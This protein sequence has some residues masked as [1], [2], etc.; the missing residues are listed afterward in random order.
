MSKLVASLVA[1][2]TAAGVLI[3]V[4]AH[5]YGRKE[6]RCSVS[7]RCISGTTIA[8]SGLNVCYWKTDSTTY[9]P[10]FVECDNQG[11]SYCGGLIE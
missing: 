2:I 10:G 7:V 6:G 9:S 3:P 11:P 1:A 4:V 5:A 8:C